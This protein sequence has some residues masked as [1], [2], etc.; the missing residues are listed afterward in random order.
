LDFNYLI[1]L[2]ISFPRGKGLRILAH[3]EEEQEKGKRGILLR[4]LE[5]FSLMIGNG[6]RRKVLITLPG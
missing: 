5:D 4:R 2:F 3:P 6:F 1:L